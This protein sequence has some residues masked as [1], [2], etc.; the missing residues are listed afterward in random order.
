MLPRTTSWAIF[1]RPCGTECDK[2]WELIVFSEH[3]TDR[4]HQK[5]NLDKIDCQPSL[6]AQPN[7]GLRPGLVSA[8]AAQINEHI[9]FG[10][11]V[12]RGLYA[13][14]GLGENRAGLG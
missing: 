2:L 6:R 7:P 14:G 9:S 3:V 4:A 5:V 12:V 1:S 11:Q 8:R 13:I 10:V